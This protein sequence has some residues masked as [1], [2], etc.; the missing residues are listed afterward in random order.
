MVNKTEICGC[1]EGKALEHLA[2]TGEHVLN[3]FLRADPLVI[4]E[5]DRAISA[6]EA[7]AGVE[8]NRSSIHQ[9]LV[10]EGNEAS[11]KDTLARPR[12]EI[13]FAQCF[14]PIVTQVTLESYAVLCKINEVSILE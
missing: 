11:S 13:S 8:T 2:V 9:S 4:P 3:L 1:D 14:S 12:T 5:H 10:T 6:R 7:M